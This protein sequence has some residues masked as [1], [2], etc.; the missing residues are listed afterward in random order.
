MA[1]IGLILAIFGLVYV[2]KPDL[3]RRWFWKK[4]D[5]LQQKLSPQKYIRFMRFLGVV[6]LL[7]GTALMIFG[8]FE[9]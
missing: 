1:R 7:V 6:F 2:I 3:Y 8:N 4:T 9:I 5:I